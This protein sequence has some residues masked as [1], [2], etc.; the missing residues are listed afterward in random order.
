M[1]GLSFSSAA[2]AGTAIKIATPP[3]IPKIAA[4]KADF[5][6]AGQINGRRSLLG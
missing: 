3:V 6:W 4:S 2:K 1:I 5:M